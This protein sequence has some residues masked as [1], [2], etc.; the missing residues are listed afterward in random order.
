L[1][2]KYAGNGRSGSRCRRRVRVE[3]SHDDEPK[4]CSHSVPVASHAVAAKF[5]GLEMCMLFAGGGAPGVRFAPA[6]GEAG[7]EE[8]AG[9][10]RHG[11]S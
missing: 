7:G 1:C 8:A 5:R 10:E 2:C 3:V 11:D 4:L 9:E 6:T